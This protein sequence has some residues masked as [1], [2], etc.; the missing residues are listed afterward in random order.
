WW[1]DRDRS[2]Y[3]RFWREQLGAG[4]ASRSVITRSRRKDDGNPGPRDLQH[5]EVS[6][7]DELSSGITQLARQLR[8]TPSVVFQAGWSL[9]LSALTRRFDVT[10]GVAFSGRTAGIPVPA[11]TVGPFVNDLPVRVRIAPTQRLDHWLASLR[12][13]QADLN[14]YQNV[15]PLEVHEWT[16]LPAGLRLFDSLIVFQNY[17]TGDAIRNWGEHIRLERFSAGVRTNYPLTV[18]VTPGKRYCIEFHYDGN[19]I[20]AG[21]VAALGRDLETILGAMVRSPDVRIATII[22]H[23][24]PDAREE[25]TQGERRSGG[26]RWMRRAGDT[27]ESVA[28][29]ESNDDDS[30][31]SDMQRTVAAVCREVIGIDDLDAGKNFFDIGAQ[32][33]SLLEIHDRLQKRLKRKFPIV[34]LFQHPTIAA[35]SRYLEA[36]EHNALLQGAAGRAAQQRAALQRRRRTWQTGGFER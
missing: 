11:H 32:S 24:S 14:H 10:M 31:E 19:A 12:S 30:F 3:A 28:T 22:N 4:G 26:D 2:D 5:A 25:P 27:R 7:S 9:L 15:S 13:M 35:L 1:M 20:D 23:V 29:P 33:V 8:L 6:L 18:A 36:G 21:A 17:A 34:K 16:G